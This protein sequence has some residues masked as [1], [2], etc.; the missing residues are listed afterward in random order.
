MFGPKQKSKPHCRISRAAL[1]GRVS[2]P[3]FLSV[4][5]SQGL[6]A[7]AYD[8]GS[9]VLHRGDIRWEGALSKKLSLSAYSTTLFRRE[10]GSK[11]KVLI[12]G[13]QAEGEKISG[14]A[15]K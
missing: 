9:L 8:E 7:V 11:Q 5:D 1:S 4:D 12:D 6:M 13:R 10:R 3:T 2:S 15:F 14:M